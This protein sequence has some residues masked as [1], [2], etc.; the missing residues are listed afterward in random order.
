M[1]VQ[2][3]IRRFLAAR[4]KACRERNVSS[5]L[6]II[7]ATATI[8]D[9]ADHMNRLT[10]WPFEVIPD[11]EDGSPA[12][13]RTLLHIEGPDHGAAAESTMVDLLSR[14]LSMS[15]IGSFIAFHNSRQ[16]VERIARSVDQDDVLPYR[17]G[18]EVRD[19][20]R[21]EQALRLGELRGVISTS[22]LEL[23]I[24]IAQ[25]TVGLNVGVPQSKK[26][27]R[28]RLGRIGRTS[29]GAFAV[30]APRH[31][32]AQFGSSFREYYEG[33]VEPSHLYLD[34]R[35]IQ[36]AQARC[37]ID[38]SE[39]LG[40]EVREPPPGVSWPDTFPPIYEAAK[41]GVRRPR[42]FE[43]IAQLG[44]NSPHFNYPLRQVGEANYKLTEG[45]KDFTE[46]VGDIALNQAIREAYPGAIYLHL[47]RPMKVVEWRTTSFDRSIRLETARSPAPIRP[48]LR[49]TVN[50]GIGPSEIVD[51]R[52]KS[53]PT[54][55]LAEAYLQVN[56]SVEGFRIGSKAFP[57]RELR[58]QD[59]RMTR[60]QREFRTTGVILKIE[61]PWF[62]GGDG[63]A[64]SVRKSVAD[65]LTRLLLREKS[66]SPND[67][68]NAAANIAFYDSGA[69]KR[70]VDTI[71]IYDSIYGGLRLTEPL[72]SDLPD[73]LDKLDK[74]AELAG[75][76]AFVP[77]DI[78]AKLRVW[79][80][81]MKEGTASPERALAPA[82]GEYVIYTP[83][84]E[85]AVLHQGVFV[86]RKLLKPELFSV[87]D[88][89]MLMYSY[90]TDGRAI[91][92]VPHDQIQSTGQNWS[93]SYWDPKTGVI[94][95]AEQEDGTF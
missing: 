31:A 6:Q 17:S 91:G 39:A 49:R 74:A 88:T 47:R 41:P 76:D 34:N 16:G 95:P 64:S 67:V 8:A 59:P 3:L 86:D 52:I 7:A 23:G 79:L 83:G 48:M 29:R 26:S 56:E 42:E 81:T 66:I 21:I 51:G 35:F 75:A 94:R 1:W 40:I 10:G 71:V 20:S 63:K 46:L 11:S 22:A 25:F 45:S 28:Q 15:K 14:I 36:F 13:G 82:D 73:F 50:V 54:G 30:L 65:G 68:D 19:R 89:N 72:F 44:A 38:E 43:F 55:L 53:G 78:A 4:R 57:Y 24:D 90:E 80:G 18:Y 32:F 37:L 9:P 93:F 85:V 69:P 62:S 87:G 12:Y 77:E 92:W 60:K 27:F 2:T 70:V 33:S 61:E 58:A 5:L 84:S